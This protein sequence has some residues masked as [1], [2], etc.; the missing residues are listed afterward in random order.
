MMFCSRWLVVVLVPGFE[1]L[2]A[3]K[4]F[5]YMLYSVVMCFHALKYFFWV[6]EI[7]FLHPYQSDVRGNR[8]AI[9]SAYSKCHCSHNA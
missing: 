8:W 9:T 7:P 2:R 5:S 6:A 1:G 4:W 3:L